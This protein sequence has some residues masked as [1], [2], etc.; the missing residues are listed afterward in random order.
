MNMLCIHL[1]NKKNSPES[2][3]CVT[4]P[5]VILSKLSCF[6]CWRNYVTNFGPRLLQGAVASSQIGSKCRIFFYWRK[7]IFRVW[8]IKCQRIKSL[9]AREPPKIGG[10]HVLQVFIGSLCQ[11]FKGVFPGFQFFKKKSLSK[12]IE[13][14]QFLC[15]K[16]D[17]RVKT[18]LKG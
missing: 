13:L 10:M 12:G 17:L 7:V 15:Y 2:S 6:A 3:R 8:L 1:Y 5:E 4:K 11:N 9:G 16:D 18:Q 14:S